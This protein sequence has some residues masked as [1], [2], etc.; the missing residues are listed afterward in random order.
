[1]IRFKFKVFK[2][3]SGVSVFAPP[4][5]DTINRS[6]IL[7]VFSSNSIHYCLFRAEALHL[8]RTKVN[9]Y[10]NRTLIVSC[11]RNCT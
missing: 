11:T 5:F 1:M 8:K 4:L 2:V 10:A 6:V 9:H 7:H 3:R